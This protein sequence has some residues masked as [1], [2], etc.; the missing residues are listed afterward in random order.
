M[1]Y[2]SEISE[3][4]RI[5]DQY[6]GFL[7]TKTTKFWSNPRFK[8]FEFPIPE[9]F[10]YDFQIQDNTLLGKR[11]EAFFLKALSA[12][13][14]YEILA[15]QIQLIDKGITLG[16][17]DFILKD[18]VTNRCYHVELSYKLYLLDSSSSTDLKYWVGP[19]KRDSLYKKWNKLCD[20]QF[21]NVYTQAGIEILNNLDIRS[22]EIQQAVYMPLQLFLPFG[23]RVE[24]D[25]KYLPC[26]VGE[27]ISFYEFQIKDWTGYEF[28]IPEKQDWFV[29]PEKCKNWFIKDAIIPLLQTYI[30]AGNSRLV[31]IKLPDKRRQKCFVT[32]WE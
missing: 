14:R 30:H 13:S 3:N 18:K 24:V 28:F 16:E 15:S 4:A 19:N 8:I 2:N 29:N 11:A 32:F 10:S 21:P 22:E 31:W 9:Q 20:S 5:K 25:K 27:W 1:K 6:R 7:A 23:K 17:L 12:Q 26:V